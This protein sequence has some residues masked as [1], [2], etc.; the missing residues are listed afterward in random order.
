MD[1]LHHPHWWDPNEVIEI[2]ESGSDGDEVEDVYNFENNAS[3]WLLDDEEKRKQSDPF[4]SSNDKKVNENDENNPMSKQDDV[5]EPL[6]NKLGLLVSLVVMVAT[7]ILNVIYGKLQMIPM[8]RFILF[9]S[10]SPFCSTN[11][12]L[13]KNRLN[14]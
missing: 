7:G 13:W 12:R 5:D 8:V 11:S 10:W 9:T 14:M 1:G 3:V 4:L 2:P 6:S